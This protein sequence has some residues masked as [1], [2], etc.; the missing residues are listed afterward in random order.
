MTKFCMWVDIQYLIMCV[1]FGDDW[2]RGLGVAMGR[3]S[4]FP[5]DLGRRLY[6]TVALPCE[7]VK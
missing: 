7:C 3:I 6:N 4:H 5:I 1:S 2:L